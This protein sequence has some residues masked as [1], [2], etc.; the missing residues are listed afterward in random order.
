[1][2]TKCLSVKLESFVQISDKA[3]KATAFD[4][5]TAIIP[6]SQYFG[7][8]YD[9]QKS[10]AYWIS[11]WILKKKDLQYSA[12]KE[13]WFDSETCDMLPTYHVEHYKPKK[14]NKNVKPIKELK[15]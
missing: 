13:A 5:S 15:K 2:K 12:K 8:D 9:V 3:F 10:D 4:G 14:I 1:M 7:R 11:E 6:A